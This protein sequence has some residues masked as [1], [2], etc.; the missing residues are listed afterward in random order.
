MLRTRKLVLGINFHANGTF[1]IVHMLYFHEVVIGAIICK[2]MDLTGFL[3]PLVFNQNRILCI[4]EL[5]WCRLKAY[6]VVLIPLNRLTIGR[7][8]P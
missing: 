6:L 4:Y 7:E 5:V 8:A 2:N 1:L 3:S